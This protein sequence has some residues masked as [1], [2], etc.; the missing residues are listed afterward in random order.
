[1]GWHNPPI[2][3]NEF[4]RRLSWGTQSAEEPGRDEL[5]P[6]G[7]RVLKLPE[8]QQPEGASSISDGSLSAVGGPAW[9]ELHCHSSYSFLD[10]ASDPD[11]LVAEAVRL[12]IEVLGITDH[13]G[14]YG[15]ARLAEAARDFE[16]KTVFGAEL[17]LGLSERQN[18]VPDPA[19]SHLLV[20]ARDVEGYGRLAGAITAAQMRGGKGRPAY[21]LAELAQAH[22]GHWVVLTGCRKGVVPA[23][24]ARGGPDAADRELHRLVELFGRGNVYVELIDHDQPLDDARNDAL[25]Q[26]ANHVGVGVVASNN[27]HYAAPA[28]APL[29]QVLAA[30]RSRRSLD[31]MTGWLPANGTAHIR[32]GREMAA[33]L[34]RFPGVREVTV[35]LARSCAFDFKVIAPRL[36]PRK[37]G[38]GHTD[39]SWLR[40]KVEEG[41]QK[42]YVERGVADI[43]KVRKQLD[44]E[45]TVI[46]D[47][48]FPGYFLIVYEIT[49]FCTEKG[50]LCQGRG[51]AANSAVCYALG[52]TAVEPI[53][54]NLLFERFL[55]DARVGPPD[56]DVDIENSR[57]EEV[58]QHV[59]DKCGRDRAAMVANV[60]TY[61]PKMAV[62]DA[63]RALGYSAGQADAWSRRVDYRIGP[64]VGPRGEKEP[65]APLPRDVRDGDEMPELLSA[66]VERMLRLPRH[67]SIHSGGVVLCDRPIGEVCPVEWATMPERSVLQWDKDDCAAGGLV[68]FDLLGL[69]M[70]SAL[71]E[72]FDLLREHH[73]GTLGLHSLPD[74]D[75]GVYDMLCDAD[76]VGV[77][78]VESR[79]Q[80][81]TLPR[82]RPRKFY[83]L[84]VEVALIRPGPIQG[85]S[86]HP[87]IRRANGKEDVTY[88]HPLMEPAL[89]RTKGVPLFQE[90]MMQLA[91]DCAD[92]DGTEADHLRQAMSSKRSIERIERL[93]GR[94]LSGMAKKDIPDDVAEDIYGKL[95]GFASYGFPESH[96][97]SFAYLV[98]ASAYLKR[99][100][101]AAFTTALLNNQPMGFYVPQTLIADARR[102]GVE[103]RGVDVNASA[104]EATLEEPVPVPP[105]V[106]HAPE[107]PQPAIR[108]GLSTVRNLGDDIAQAIAASRPYADL[109]DLVRRVRVPLPALEALATAGAFGCFELERREAL[110]AVGALAGTRPD[111]L[112]GTT[113]GS[114]APALP[115][116]TATEMTFADLWATGSSPDT[117]PVQH[118]RERLDNWGAVPAA[119]LKDVAN[120]ER[121][122]VGGLVTHRQRPPTAGGVVFMN[123]EDETGMVNVICP[124]RTWERQRR[125]ALDSAAL[126]VDGTLECQDG[127]INLLAHRL[128]PLRIS[129]EV[130]SRNFR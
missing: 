19:G 47:L 91:I 70:L 114:R 43:E 93:R 3:W 89:Q 128:A 88:P 58:I 75:T 71:R 32:S 124:K 97:Y 59:Y 96:A 117:H 69:G 10:G 29:A 25:F 79:A 64:Q 66:V 87:Y 63:A 50:I 77:F 37:L 122:L 126:V 81:A 76:S 55:T 103:V 15:V 62:R 9:A 1:M 105:G 4:E 16:L 113:P 38:E 35:E 90:Q 57:R 116:M 30:V 22:G 26:L 31:E 44:K 53:S 46:E 40:L 83:D 121:V 51:S 92:F 74:D 112:P 100:H 68:K 28:D 104:A 109:A 94:L 123:V 125:I 85:G 60:N 84:V 72:S 115:A 48:E 23:A 127:A 111:Q 86:V 12:G 17:S 107:E 13:D 27:V 18:G 36:P 67:L 108:L 5:T 80:M 61:R 7:A 54:N 42:R 119:A 45:L 2:P 33:R 65:A 20:L 118:V 41:F 95:F 24:L 99:Y 102:H 78:Q 8:R 49:Q 39:A 11:A 56:I 34:G 14:M 106:A 120:G 52:I 21:N 129:G 101:P 82:L 98:Y 6:E 110:W 130:P 73:G